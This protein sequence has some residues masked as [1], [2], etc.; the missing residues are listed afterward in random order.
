MQPI[1]F[2]MEEFLLP[3]SL[4]LKP[5]I[6]VD[7]RQTYILDEQGI[8]RHP[9]IITAEA[10]AMSLPIHNISQRSLSCLLNMLDDYWCCS[11]GRPGILCPKVLSLCQAV[12]LLISSATIYLM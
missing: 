4:A 8:Q 2:L 7:E 9:L 10:Y 3:L 12:D 5:G 6:M 1:L 11:K